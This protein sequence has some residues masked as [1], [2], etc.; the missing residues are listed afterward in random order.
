MGGTRQ[1]TVD[2]RVMAAT[3]RNLQTRVAEGKFR[4]DLYYR[5][6]MFPLEL[7][8]LRERG[9]DI[10]KLARS[11][12][13]R[14]SHCLKK[15]PVRLTAE[16][17]AVLAAYPWPKNVRELDQWNRTRSLTVPAL[18]RSRARQQAVVTIKDQR[19]ELRVEV[20]MSIAGQGSH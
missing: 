8:P 2:V 11:F 13:I 3:N 10:V 9:P 20:S 7:P 18:S 19:E 15:Q 14:A 4:E 12:L 1:I 5:V 17:E 6:S 16:A